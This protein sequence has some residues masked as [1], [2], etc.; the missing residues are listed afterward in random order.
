MVLVVRVDED[1]EGEGAR[2]VLIVNV[3][4]DETETLLSHPLKVEAEEVAVRV[5]PLLE[6]GERLLLLVGHPD[7]KRRIN[8][9]DIWGKRGAT[10]GEKGVWRR[11]ENG[12][13]TFSKEETD[14]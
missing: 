3:C 10:Y 6:L 12:R 4:E 7:R 1:L 8:I 13:E 14:G 11:I 9:S 2:G 5:D